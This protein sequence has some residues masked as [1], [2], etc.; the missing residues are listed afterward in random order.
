MFDA[1]LRPLIDPPLNAAGRTVAA[2]GLTANAVT[3]IGLGF[4][5]AAAGL[6]AAGYPLMA[7]PLLLANRLADGLDGAVARATERTDL[8]GYLDI[9]FDFLFYGAIP[10]AFALQDP[11]SN[12]LAAAVLLLSFYANGAAFLTFA[13]MAERKRLE[14]SRRGLKSLYYLGG[15]AEGAETILVFALM[16][17]WPAGFAL[18]AYGFA[19]LCGVSAA[20]RI[21]TAI[22]V[23]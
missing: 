3:V 4:G 18:L 1:H 22:R 13:I 6:I 5:L 15:L 7:L 9:V 17:L 21:A 19:A 14:T 11:S 12:A 10:L 20:A 8:G 23:L 16:C 2:I